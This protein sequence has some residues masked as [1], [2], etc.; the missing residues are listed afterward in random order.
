LER[1][2]PVVRP[3]LRGVFGALSLLMY[4]VGDIVERRFSAWRPQLP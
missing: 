2:R 3:P 4:W 1:S